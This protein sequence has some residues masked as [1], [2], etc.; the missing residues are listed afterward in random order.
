MISTGS[1]SSGPGFPICSP[2]VLQIAESGYMFRSYWIDNSVRIAMLIEV[3]LD[4]GWILL[5]RLMVT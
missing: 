4:F 5:K 3:Y 2:H 1:L